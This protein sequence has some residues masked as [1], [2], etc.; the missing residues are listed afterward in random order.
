VPSALEGT[1]QSVRLILEPDT[2][3]T[4]LVRLEEFRMI[5]ERYDEQSLPEWQFELLD[6]TREV[7][8][9]RRC[10]RLSTGFEVHERRIMERF[11]GVHWNHPFGKCCKGAIHRSGDFRRCTMRFAG[12][13]LRNP[14]IVSKSSVGR[15]RA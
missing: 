6:Q 12:C 4:F 15:N 3:G 14:H 11:A 1:K 7:L 2:G 5:E 13:G 9:N 10:L 8:E